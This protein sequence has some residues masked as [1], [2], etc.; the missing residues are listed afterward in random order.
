MEQNSTREIRLSD[1]LSVLKRCWIVMLAVLLVVFAGVY[2]FQTQTHVDEYQSTSAIYVISS[3]ENTLVGNNMYYQHMIALA[4][5]ADFKELVMLDDPVL[6]PMIK[7]LRMDGME[8]KD[9]R[10]MITIKSEEDSRLLYITATTKSPEESVQIC[11]VFS[12]YACRYFNAR[13]TNGTWEVVRVENQATLPTQPSNPVSLVKIGLIAAVCA[14]LVYAVYF[15]IYLAD[16]K[17][18]TA[19]DVEKHLGLSMLGVIPNR[20]GATRK[21][22]K[23]G[24]YYYKKYGY[25]GNSSKK[26]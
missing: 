19:E 24:G 7:D 10:K 9:L 1:L 21:T 15:I 4:Y 6:R 23:Q 13:M 16:D 8:P 2:I 12:A 14:L 5:A 11:R 18:H 26:K 20:H 22:A 25:Y 3:A 17:I